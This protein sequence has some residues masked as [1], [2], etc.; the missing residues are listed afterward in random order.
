MIYLVD[1]PRPPARAMGSENVHITIADRCITTGRTFCDF[2][3]GATLKALTEQYGFHFQSTVRR[4]NSSTM[5]H[6]VRHCARPRR[7]PGP[8]LAT[9]HAFLALAA[10]T[11]RGVTVCISNCCLYFARRW[12]LRRQLPSFRRTTSPTCLRYARGAPAS[13]RSMCCRCATYGRTCASVEVPAGVSRVRSL[14]GVAFSSRVC[15]E[16]VG[17]T[18]L[19]CLCTFSVKRCVEKPRMSAPQWD[20]YLTRMQ[21]IECRPM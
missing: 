20:G 17:C 7:A 14:A 5:S 2:V 21:H 11:P 15:D 8:I 13:R 4:A 10:V 12:D 9:L 19:W 18:Q 1:L 16:W 3:A 6:F